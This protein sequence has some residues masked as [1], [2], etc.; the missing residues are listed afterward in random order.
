MPQGRCTNALRP[1]QPQ[2]RRL[3]STASDLPD[4]NYEFVTYVTFNTILCSPGAIEGPF[5]TYCGRVD[6][7]FLKLTAPP[8]LYAKITVFAIATEGWRG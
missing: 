4:Q 6:I 5:L 1:R 3:S 2:E 8:H 7:L